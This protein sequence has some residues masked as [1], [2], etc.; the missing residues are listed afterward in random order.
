MFLPR[1]LSICFY[2]TVHFFFSKSFQFPILKTLILS[3]PCSAS[4]G[5]YPFNIAFYPKFQ[6]N[7]D[8]GHNVCGFALRKRAERPIQDRRRESRT[9]KRK[10]HSNIQ[11]VLQRASGH[12]PNANPQT[13]GRHKHIQIE[14]ALFQLFVQQTHKHPT[15]SRHMRIKLQTGKVARGDKEKFDPHKSEEKIQ[16]I[17]LREA[18]QQASWLDERDI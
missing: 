1:P 16:S 10:N 17:G 14:S 4:S 9:T 15:R 6:I 5:F 3:S 8:D 12:N 7:R 13:H 18:V 11:S 2:R